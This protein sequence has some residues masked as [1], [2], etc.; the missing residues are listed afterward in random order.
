MFCFEKAGEEEM[1]MKAKGYDTAEQAS[2]KM[3][4]VTELEYELEMLPKRERKQMRKR[5]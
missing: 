2:E 4:Q 1:Y 5:I 3:T